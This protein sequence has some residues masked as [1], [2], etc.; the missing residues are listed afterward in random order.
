MRRRLNVLLLFTG[1]PA[2][3]SCGTE[4]N[5]MEVRLVPACDGLLFPHLILYFQLCLGYEESCGGQGVDRRTREPFCPWSPLWTSLWEGTAALWLGRFRTWYYC[6]LLPLR[7]LDLCPWGYFRVKS[8]PLIN[9]PP[10]YSRRNRMG[11]QGRFSNRPKS[12]L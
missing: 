2:G 6:F 7:A 12:A 11:A 3:P 1:Y 8:G 9:S 10:F 5:S 4:S